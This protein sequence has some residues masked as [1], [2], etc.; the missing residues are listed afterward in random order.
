MVM[1]RAGMH[2][3][4][5]PGTIVFGSD[6]GDPPAEKK[7]VGQGGGTAKGPT[8]ILIVE[9][10]YLVGALAEQALSASGYDVV[11]VARS[12]AEAVQLAVAYRPALVVMD[13]RLHD[14]DGVAA[15]IEIFQST[16][17]R[18]LFASAHTDD[19]TRARAASAKPLGWLSKP[20]RAADIVQAVSTILEEQ[21]RG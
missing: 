10:E 18:C 12:A 15:A 5:D 2:R 7:S 19:V 3:G 13:I 11:G 4:I 8:R 20:Y 14:S 16:G 17:T 6:D 1:D 21:D 9:D